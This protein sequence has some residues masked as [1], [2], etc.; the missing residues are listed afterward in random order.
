MQLH[1]HGYICETKAAK[2]HAGTAEGMMVVVGGVSR[3]NLQSALS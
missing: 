2:S 3:L 1:G